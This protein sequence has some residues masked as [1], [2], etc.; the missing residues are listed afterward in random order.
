MKKIAIAADHA[1]YEMKEFL[2]GYL[3]SLGWDVFDFGCHSEESCDYPD[4]G[5]QL[6]EAVAKGEF[7]RGISVCGSGVGISMVVNR[8]AGVRGALCWEPEI[9][10]L[11]REH[12]DANVLCLPGR[13]MENA[14]A[15]Q[16]VDIF[17][18]TPFEGGR[19]QRRVEKIELA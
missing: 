19:H 5:H 14:A 8:H 18:E 11:C 3:S 6:A 10:R 7:E 12:N 13:F 16:C 4:M 1:G 2:V 17:L 15:R 9:A